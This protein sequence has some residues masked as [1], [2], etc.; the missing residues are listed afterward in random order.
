MQAGNKDFE[1]SSKEGTTMNRNPNN[2]IRDRGYVV[3]DSKCQA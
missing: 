3:P 2:E 1:N